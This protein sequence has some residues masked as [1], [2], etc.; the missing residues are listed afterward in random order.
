MLVGGVA[1]AC[2]WSCWCWWVKLLVLAGGV[3]G[4]S[5]RPIWLLGAKLLVSE[6][7][8]SALNNQT[9]F[10]AFLSF[11]VIQNW[12]G[13]ASTSTVL[14]PVASLGNYLLCMTD[15]AITRYF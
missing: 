8:A 5:E 15:G 11:E 4:V 14:F 6:R 3:A 1:G 10:P 13:A 9:I 12:M 7:A 2:G